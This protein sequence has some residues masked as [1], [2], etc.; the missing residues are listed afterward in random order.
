MR[1]F[2]VAASI[3]WAIRADALRA[4]L[5]LAARAEISPEIV[6]AAM[7]SGTP[8]AVAARLGRPLDNARRVNVRDGVAVIPI[9]GPIFRY[10]NLFSDISGATST[11]V[12][13]TDLSV[14]LD[15][16]AIAAILLEIDSPGGEVSGTAELAQM[17]RAASERKPV[18]AFVDTFGASAA[19]WLAAATERITVASTALVGSI[20][21]VLALPDPE[22]S[23]QT[24]IEFV[25]SQ[26]P[27]KSVDVGTE[28]GRAQ[29]QRIVDDLAEVF[30]ADVA[31]YRGVVPETVEESFGQGDVFVG[32]YAV[33]SGL[34][35]AV[36][37][38]EQALADV[39]TVAATRPLAGAGRSSYI[40]G[41]GLTFDD[42]SDRVQGAVAE[43]VERVKAG[44]ATRLEEGRA[45]STSRRARM[46][47]VATS[48]RVAAGEIHAMLEETV[49]P[50][51]VADETG[52]QAQRVAVLKLRSEFDRATARRARELGVSA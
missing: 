30:I 20:G 52:A 37:T 12:I 8:E 1:A 14:A 2:D 24:D 31:R 22:R 33:E 26:S 45:I 43:W 21:V 29:V 28:S 34:V 6:A 42:H 47:G 19:Y 49:S 18:H 5:K 23:R 39:A 4:I 48:L 44:T 10:A 15:D 41:H 16:P 27:K 32:R 40:R 51:T 17:I 9:S 25:S 38:F 50:E 3:P 7:T 11:E 35:D 36:G 46:E 13:A